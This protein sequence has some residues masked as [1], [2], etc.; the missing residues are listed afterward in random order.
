MSEQIKHEC[1][2]ALIRLLKPMEYYHLKYG[3]W[4]YGLQKLYL[5]MEKQHN[6][7]Q[8]GAGLT[9]LKFD[10]EPGKRYIDRERSNSDSSIKDIFDAVNRSIN[11]YGHRPE[12][13]GDSAW[14]KENIPFA[15]EIYLGHL[16]YGTFGNN[17][18]D[19]VHPV[20]RDNNWKSR[21]LVLAGNFNMTNVD[22]LFNKLV[23]LGQHPRDYSDTVTVLEKIGHFLDEENQQVFRQY[24]NEGYSNMEISKLIAENI[25]IGKILQAATKD[26]DGGYAIAGL[27]GHGDAFVIRDPW[28]IRPAFYYLNDEFAV[29]ASERSAIQTVMNVKTDDVKEVNPGYGL[30]IKR[31]GTITHEEI[32]VPQQR[33]SCSFERIYFSR[34]S[35]RDI[36]QERKKLG[37]LLTPAILKAINYDH[38][39]TV[40]SYIPNTAETAFYGMVK[41]VEDYLKVE[42]KRMILEKSSSLTESDL[43]EVI[44]IRLRVEKIAVKDVKLRTFISQDKGRE[45]L[46]GHVYDITY[47]AI[48]PGI[49]SLVVIDDSIVRGTTLKESILRILDRLN[50]VSVVVVSSSPQIRYPDCYG[51]DMAK[52]SDFVAFKAAVGLLHDTGQEAIIN[53]VYRKCKEQ[54]Y[55]PK[56]EIVN[57]V[58]EIY[59]PFTDDQLAEKIAQ[60]LTPKDMRAK[61]KIVYQS[62]ENL[63]LAC[64][65]DLGDWYFTG[66][67]PTPGG[68]RVVNNSFIN[69]IEG[70]NNR[71]YQ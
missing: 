22:E 10:L 58:K 47:G 21:T 9:S 54:Q 18:I 53:K 19:Y 69:F 4:Q 39:N 71:A 52:L 12:L 35:D 56:E 70:R 59:S 61:V 1:G 40:F 46:V 33:R 36:Y 25:N 32:R 60:L 41:G 68:N 37:E 15:G 44:A 57:Y 67:Y 24:K 64:P 8:D 66:N 43:D 17:S 29:V 30:I 13:A 6:R 5:L 16:R 3:T 38:S 2:I 20:M 48:R 50:P 11:Q 26:F 49:D 27:I 28:G 65:N 51:I 23:S 62:I 63:H 14:A 42:K 55:L 7:G 31:N 34:G 45:D